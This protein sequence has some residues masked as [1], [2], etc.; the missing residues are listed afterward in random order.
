MVEIKFADVVL[1]HCICILIEKISGYEKV[2]FVSF[3]S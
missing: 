3:D 2:A 1:I